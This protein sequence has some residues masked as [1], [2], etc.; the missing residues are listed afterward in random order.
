MASCLD[1]DYSIF[2]FHDF[3]KIDFLEYFPLVGGLQDI[4]VYLGDVIFQLLRSPGSGIDSASLFSLA[5][6]YDKTVPTLVLKF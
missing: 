4:R 2:R 1:E 5:N 3:K 6:R